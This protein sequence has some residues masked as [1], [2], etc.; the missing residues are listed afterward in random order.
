M[1]LCRPRLLRLL[2]LLG[3]LVLLL[4]AELAQPASGALASFDRLGLRVAPGFRVTLYAD[5]N[6][7][8]NIYAMTLD[9]R[10][11]VVVTSQGYIKTL[12]DTNGD[13]VADSANLFATTQT[14]GMGLCFDGNDLYFAGDGAFSRYSDADG[15]GVADGPAQRLLGVNFSEHGG[16]AMRK[17]PDGVWYLIGGNESGFDKRNMTLPGSPGRPVEAGALLRISSD[18]RN[19]EVIAHGFRNPYDF[20]FNFLGDLFTYDSDGEREFLLPWY[21][22]SRIF[23]VGQ[24]GHHGWRLSG[25]LR[26]WA[27]PDYSPD[28]VDI[29]ARLGRGSPTGVVCYRH[30]QYPARYRNGLFALDWTFGRVYFLPLQ[31]NGA[32]YQ[33]LPEIF[34]E[35]IGTH[36]FAPTD[37][38][39]A[40]DGALLI[41][42]GGRKTRGAIYR[43]EYVA[44]G[45]AALAARNWL[46]GAASELGAVL[47]APQPLDAWSRAYWVPVAARLGPSLF[48]QVVADT[49]F[50][51]A[52]R[53]RAVEVLTELHGGLATATA[54]AGAKANSPLV[55]A[56]VAWSLGRSPCENFAPMLLGLA[57]DI[58][59]IVRRCA[60]EALADNVGNLDERT[61]LQALAA[62]LPHP[63]KRVRQAAA[64]LATYLP[65]PAWQA[66]WKQVSD[67]QARLT[68]TL[69]QLWRS[70]P[71]AINVEAIESALSILSQNA[72]SAHRLQAIRLIILALGDYHLT[73]PSL[74]V[75]TAY[76]PALSLEGHEGLMSRV[77]RI[78]GSMIPSG[79]AVVNFEAARLLAMLEDDDR[80]LPGRI[81]AFISERSS[82]ASDFHYLTALS[83]LKGPP[84]TNGAPKIAH[85]I[86]CLNRKLEGQEKRNKQNWTVRLTEVV[87]QMVKREPQLADAFLRYPEFAVPA[88]VPLVSSLGP[89]H[90]VAAAQ[91]FLAAIKKKPSFS[92]SGPL[93]DLLGALPVTEV[94]P[95][96]RGQWSNAALRDDLLFELAQNPEA[97]DRGKFMSGLSSLQ[98]PAARASLSAL[99]Q[100]PSAQSTNVLV[101]SLR[102]L[103]RLFNEP[104]EQTA[105]S[106]GVA[107]VNRETGQS[108]KVQEQGTDPAN[109]RR[110]YQPL[111]DWFAKRHPTLVRELDAEDQEDPVRWDLTLKAVAWDKGDALRGEQLFTER[112][113]LTC[114]I[115]S[116]AL[117]PDLGGVA[118]RFSPIDLFNAIIFPSRE[119]A[120]AYRQ[121]VV[122]T[123]DGQTYTGRVV[124]ESADGVILQTGG[125]STTIR[126][127][128]NDIL[129]R[130]GSPLSIMPS[131][132][133]AGLR[134]SELANLYAYLRTLQPQRLN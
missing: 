117:G 131:G 129:N 24:G 103:R 96:F 65:D 5:S 6:L 38:V 26:S 127:A 85:A 91:L 50:I 13:G 63:E 55:R 134:S 128:E 29:L 87:K 47:I 132:L 122:R 97:L 42:I 98:L 53:I 83:R 68:I 58:D 99:L 25:H 116:T 67:P 36:G 92:W 88:H 73:A 82:A 27:R 118:G 81:F 4:F 70:P 37:I 112:G 2:T 57:R 45:N 1:S 12:L 113:C 48:D 109:L 43:I 15:D 124:Y 75:Y 39:V 35:P 95:L 31:L 56:R 22:P 46:A 76:E 133:L 21:V 72:N 114:H 108:F 119:V 120:P 10:G 93:I 32:S 62:N 101:P 44:E 100:L 105:R 9:A 115:G 102:L 126:L 110:V 14:G 71:T 89:E 23:H 59:P 69:A 77:R 130:Q 7:A 41:S 104:K 121:T 86:L 34:L 8:D 40:P 79:D 11:N 49:G 90:Q 16:H 54:V 61:I 80:T 19:S 51:P 66:F 33:T 64:R 111:F 60:L 78:V 18:G 30:Y 17:G 74:E 107:L 28:T 84:L 106:E 52:S 3:G 94:R 125:S 20:D 123:R